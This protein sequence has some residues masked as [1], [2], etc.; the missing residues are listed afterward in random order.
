MCAVQ[1]CV[2]ACGSHVHRTFTCAVQ[3]CVCMWL[4]CTQDSHVCCTVLCV[5]VAHMYAGQSRVLYSLV[6]ACGSHVLCAFSRHD[7]SLC[8]VGK[9]VTSVVT[10]LLCVHLVIVNYGPLYVVWLNVHFELHMTTQTTVQQYTY[11][12]HT[13]YTRVQYCITPI[14]CTVY[15][16][17]VYCLCG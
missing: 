7:L 10:A 1:S 14:H 9:N 16:C 15:T 3:S 11:L 12:T 2:C 5:H 13:L 6:C 17:C 8:P 4:T